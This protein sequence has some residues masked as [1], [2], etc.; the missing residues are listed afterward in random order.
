M[1]RA[2]AR[3]LLAAA[4][5]AAAAF[6]YTVTVRLRAAAVKPAPRPA[7]GAVRAGPLG[8]AA[9]RAG[10]SASGTGSARAA[11][12]AAGAAP[13]EPGGVPEMPPI[14][15]TVA[16]REDP[17]PGRVGVFR[18]VRLVMAEFKYALLRVEETVSRDRTSARERVLDRR[19]MVGDHVVVRLAPGADDRALERLCSALGLR[20]RRRMI[21]PGMFLV[22]FPAP[23]ADSVP[24]F[25]AA[26]SRHGDVVRYAEPD[27]LRRLAAAYPNDPSWSSL[28]GLHQASDCDIDAPEAWDVTVGSADLVA[29][30]LDTGMQYTH[31]DLASNAWV[32][33]GEIPGNGLDDDGN[34]F[35]NDVYGWDFANDDSD[36]ADDHSHG[37]H[38]AGTIG[39]VGSNG[40]GVVGV[41]WRVKL[42]AVKCFDAT[43]NGT[44]SDC[45]DSFAYVTMMRRRGVNVRVTSCSWGGTDFT[46]GLL[47]AVRDANDAG[48]LCVA[49]AGNVGWNND[50]NPYYPACFDSPNMIAVAA[51]TSSDTLAS[52]SQWGPTT[53]D[54]AAPGVNILSTVPGNGYGYKSGTSM[55]TPHVSGVAVLAFS[56]KRGLSH[57]QVKDAILRGVDPVAALS[58][59]VV[60]GGRLNARRTLLML[61]D[62]GVRFGIR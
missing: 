53:V 25:A 6:V 2:G 17:E 55:A 51:T 42:M 9:A 41:N 11:L 54:L 30:V 4:A 59:K 60:T 10:A 32:N 43:G 24:E 50:V 52:F 35:T 1:R 33:P 46:Q 29:A 58:G 20:I 22:S 62:L 40:V 49:A 45:M 47:D 61:P 7:P 15:Q 31:A 36:P 48:V 26:L 34:G 44:D 56:A 39:A 18:R 38:C 14:L 19:V 37:S 23:N 57:L 3:W 12:P 13:L 16:A 5:L 21:S 8:G 27:Y 28:W